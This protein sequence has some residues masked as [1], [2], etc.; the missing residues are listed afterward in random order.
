MTLLLRLGE[1]Q[2]HLV[3][4]RFFPQLSHEEIAP[5]VGKR[6]GSVRV[7]IHRALNK[8]RPTLQRA[9]DDQYVWEDSDGR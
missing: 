1:E 2:Q 6:A 8:L 9:L 5:L 4:L 3:C 7:R